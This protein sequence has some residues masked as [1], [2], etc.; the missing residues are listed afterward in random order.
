[1]DKPE[2]TESDQSRLKMRDNK[3][4]RYYMST[5]VLVC[6]LVALQM[7][8][9]IASALAL[10]RQITWIDIVCRALS[11]VAVIVII[12]R[13][14]STAYKLCWCVPILIFPVLGGLAYL[15]SRGRQGHRRLL[16]NINRLKDEISANLPD[17]DRTD[18]EGIPYPRL[19][20]YLGNYGFRCYKDT[21][22]S[23]FNNGES[24]YAAMLEDLSSAKESIFMEFFIIHEGSMWDSILDILRKKAAAGV[25][26]RVIYD[27]MGSIKCLPHGYAK[28]LRAMGIRTQVFHPFIP[29]IS[30]VQNNRDH[31]K[32]VLIDRKIGYTGGINISDE[33]IN[34]F[35]RCGNWKDS[36]IRLCG[37]AVRGLLQIFLE[38]WYQNA[39][40]DGTL[41][42]MLE[43]MPTDAGENCFVIP[44]SDAPVSEQ[45]IGKNVYTETITHAK[46]YLY[47]VTPYLIPGNDILGAVCQ[48]ARSGV[49]VR[50]MTPR[51]GDKAIIHAITRSYYSELIA[52][53]V[54][55]YEYQPGFVHSKLMVTDDA[56]STVGTMN[57]DYRSLYL[58]FECGCVVCHPETALAIK[59]DFLTTLQSCIEITEERAKR[60]AV[61]RLLLSLLR[62]FEP[63]L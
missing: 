30:T 33:Y 24:M 39:P 54:K 23:Y 36:G 3:P 1:M 41:R 53:G 15:I 18:D 22:V 16:R 47:I 59:N 32:I 25:D 27:G 60:P 45:N 31:R 5:F 56:L 55:V 50:I 49:D 14:V 48:S 26:V 28:K 4:I 38:T 8:V 9:L 20:N 52:A 43:P 13:K 29:V 2:I 51:I 40:L 11:I 63:L 57:L 21:E 12:N 34:R 37:A 19:A 62:V 35:D 17:D 58:H 10:S 46:E 42:Q 6:I 44:Y 7:A 61:V